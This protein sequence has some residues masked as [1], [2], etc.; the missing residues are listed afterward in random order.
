M[1]TSMK[2]VLMK[3]KGTSWSTAILFLGM[4]CAVVALTVANRDTVALVA[5][6]TVLANLFVNTLRT[7]QAIGRTDEIKDQVN[8]HLGALIEA[9][10]ITTDPVEPP[11]AYIEITNG[12][13]TARCARAKDHDGFHHMREVGA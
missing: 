13:V 10:T 2:A 5:F 1:D 8:G 11:C 12:R 6:L 7:D 3:Y 9:K 4:V